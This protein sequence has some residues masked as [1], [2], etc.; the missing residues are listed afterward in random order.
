MKSE[1]GRRMGWSDEVDAVYA[2]ALAKLSKMF[3]FHDPENAM[4]WGPAHIVWEDGNLDSAQW[5]IDNFNRNK[6][7]CDYTKQELDI[8]MWS[9]VELLKISPDH[10]L[11]EGDK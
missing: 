8:V 11:W 2:S 7:D 10:K 9:L 6:D 4:L 5:C 3:L 1:K